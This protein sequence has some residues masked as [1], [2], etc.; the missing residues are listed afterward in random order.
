MAAQPELL[1]D[2]LDKRMG[3]GGG[4]KPFFKGLFAQ[5]LL[6]GADEHHHAAGLDRVLGVVQRLLGLVE[7]QILGGAALRH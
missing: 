2:S 4:G 3:R 5:P 7:V 1:F 6:A